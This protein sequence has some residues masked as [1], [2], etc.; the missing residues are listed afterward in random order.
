MSGTAPPDDRAYTKPYRENGRIHFSMALQD[1]RRQPW[2]VA[3]TL[4]NWHFARW[5]FEC[6]RPRDPD[7]GKAA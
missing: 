7:L 6:D 1:G 2:A 3:D 4:S 5:I